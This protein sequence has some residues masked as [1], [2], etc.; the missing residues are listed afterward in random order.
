MM[1]RFFSV[2]HLENWKSPL[3][4]VI[5]VG[6]A[7]HAIPPTGGQGAAMAFEDCETLA[8]TLSR[9]QDITM[10]DA[11]ADATSV[12]GDQLSKWQKHRQDRIERVLDFTTKN[13]TLRKSSPQFYEQAAKEWVIW[14]AFRFMGPEAGAAWLYSYNAENVLGA[15]V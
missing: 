12:I 4:R 10:L 7:A 6:D 9:V 2:P 5:I 3:G 1:C 13:G 15:L 11:L 8:Y 14:V